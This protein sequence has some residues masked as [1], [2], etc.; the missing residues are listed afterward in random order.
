VPARQLPPGL[1]RQPG[2][3]R[4]RRPGQL[5]RQL[6]GGLQSGAARTDGDLLGDA[7]DNCPSA[8]NAD[9]Q[10]ADGDRV[11]DVCDNC[12]VDPNPSQTNVDLDL[13]GD[14]CDLS[15]GLILLGFD[16]PQEIDWQAEAGFETWNLYRGDLDVLKET[17]A[18]VQD[19]GSNDL[20]GQVCALD[21]PG[22]TDPTVPAPG[23]VAFFLATG[24]NADG[25]S[26]LGDG[27][28]G[29]RTGSGLCL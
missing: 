10:D 12:P 26:G 11:G 1:Q 29:S 8:A 6:S 7:G 24:V 19:P 2:R 15:D 20:A 14:T 17:G 27:S 28:G 22:V 18:Y 9:Q 5:L 25:E 16:D 3:H 21:T 13:D 4:R 23:K